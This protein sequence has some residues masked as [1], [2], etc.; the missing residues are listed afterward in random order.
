VLN[1]AITESV[2]ASRSPVTDVMADR[3]GNTFEIVV[4]K[5][6]LADHSR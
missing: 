2:V 6:P 3:S 5:K 1:R 4:M